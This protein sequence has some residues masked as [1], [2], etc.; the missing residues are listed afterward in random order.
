MKK[1][2]LLLLVVFA[3]PAL[4]PN[5]A[6]AGNGSTGA[7][8][9]VLAPE[10]KA[11]GGKEAAFA[12]TNSLTFGD[13][14]LFCFG[15]SPEGGLIAVD[16]LWE[17]DTT[18]ADVEL[19]LGVDWDGACD[20]DFPPPLGLLCAEIADDFISGFTSGEICTGAGGA[21]RP[22]EACGAPVP[23]LPKTGRAALIVI[24]MLGALLILNLSGIIR[25]A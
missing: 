21:W 9:V 17:A 13:C 8:T 16:C 3:L 1:P 25:S 22:G 12:C 20:L 6:E 23:A 24:L 19:E 4:V 14:Q 18:C 11:P 10:D 7:C 2:I 5:V 15:D